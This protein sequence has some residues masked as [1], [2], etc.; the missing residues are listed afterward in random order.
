MSAPSCLGLSVHVLR[1]H[2]YIADIQAIYK[3]AI[4]YHYIKYMS[5]IYIAI[6][7]ISCIY[8]YYISIKH[9]IIYKQKATI[10]AAFCVIYAIAPI[11]L[12]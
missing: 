8:G 11:M 10:K 12:A 1:A 7:S 3:L 6:G 5:I 4:L 9:I 2:L